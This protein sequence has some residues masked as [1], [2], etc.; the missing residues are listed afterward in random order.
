LL[1]TKVH[2]EF[3]LNFH[4]LEIL[5]SYLIC[6]VNT[7][8]CI[9]SVKPQTFFCVIVFVKK[10]LAFVLKDRKSLTFVFEYL[11][12]SC[13]LTLLE[14][15]VFNIT[16]LSFDD[17]KVLKCQLNML[18]FVQVYSEGDKNTRRGVELCFLK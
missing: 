5:E 18:I 2:L 12:V 14:Q 4:I 9:S 7:T 17:N 10:S 16:T 8:D 11:Q 15:N 1:N 6:I 3:L 13:F